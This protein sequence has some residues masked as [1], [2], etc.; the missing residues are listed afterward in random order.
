VQRDQDR[1]NDD[2][3]AVVIGANGLLLVVL[4]VYFLVFQRRVAAL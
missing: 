1:S 3:G 2:V 4:A